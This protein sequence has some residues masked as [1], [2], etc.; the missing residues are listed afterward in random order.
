VGRTQPPDFAAASFARQL[1][2]IRSGAAPAVI[3]CGPLDRVRD[4][5]DVRDVVRASL[6]LLEGDPGPG[7]FNV[8]SGIPRAMGEVLREMLALTGIRAEIRSRPDGASVT[9]IPYQC[10]SYAALRRAV[11]WE[12]SIPWRETLVDLLEDWRERVG[13]AAT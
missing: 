9:D 1:A 12:P 8:C 3:E 6:L 2:C 4:L 11:G 7:P 13:A 10:G 5:I